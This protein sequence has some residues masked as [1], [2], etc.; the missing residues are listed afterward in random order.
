MVSLLLDIMGEKISEDLGDEVSD[1]LICG[2]I[3]SDEFGR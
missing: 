2:E 1:L 3:S